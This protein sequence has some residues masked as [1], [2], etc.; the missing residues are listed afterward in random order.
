MKIQFHFYVFYLVIACVITPVQGLTLNNIELNS[1]LNQILDARIGL[2]GMKSGD[3]DELNLQVLESTIPINELPSVLIVE[4][5]DDGKGHYIHV[6]SRDNI[7]E[8]ILS[9]TLEITWAEGHL[10]RE[11][12]VLMDPKK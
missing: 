7:R 6:T 4:V 12:T 9:F 5:K 8:P 2:D 1:Y 10:I 3:I 11:Y